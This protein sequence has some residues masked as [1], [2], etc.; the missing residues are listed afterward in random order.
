[1][2]TVV[3]LTLKLKEHKKLNKSKIWAW[4]RAKVKATVGMKLGTWSPLSPPSSSPHSPSSSWKGAAAPCS[5]TSPSAVLE[6]SPASS[7]PSTLFFR[8]DQ[9]NLVL[10]RL[11]VDNKDSKEQQKK[12]KNQKKKKKK[13]KKKKS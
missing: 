3:E 6:F 5:S 4:A 13:K 9:I 7:M 1:M 11:I 12:K 8:I 10:D 2:G